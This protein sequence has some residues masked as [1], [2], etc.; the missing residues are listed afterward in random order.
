MLEDHGAGVVLNCCGAP[1]LW[2]GEREMFEAHTAEL[3]SV[4]ESFG[5]PVFIFAC[6]YCAKVFAEYMP[7]IRGISLYELLADAQPSGADASVSA[8]HNSGASDASVPGA[9]DAGTAGG[10]TESLRYAVF[11][12]CAARACGGAAGEAV[13]R[14]ARGAGIDTEELGEGVRCC[15]WGG[16]MGAPNPE[17]YETALDSLTA[18]SDRPYLVYCANCEDAL[19]RKGKE[20]THILDIVAS[21]RPDKEC[22]TDIPHLQ[23]KRARALELKREL[24]S[25][26]E[27]STEGKDCG[28]TAGPD[29][30]GDRAALPRVEMR[31]SDEVRL[32]M[33]ANFILDDD[34]AE[35]ILTAERSGVKFIGEMKG[36]SLACLERP[37]VTYWVEYRLCDDG[38]YDVYNVYSHRMRFKAD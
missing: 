2:A 36:E 6:P 32:E 29:G 24:A 21:C 17:L 37:N 27:G 4:W 16:H 25:L 3:R 38:A 13:R 30:A 33:D 12:P 11:D 19:R 8:E 28:G 10:Q 9:A 34:V 7:D 26:F 35:T 5:E 20:C 1:A 22:G 18:L 31:I 23:E 14:L 15:G